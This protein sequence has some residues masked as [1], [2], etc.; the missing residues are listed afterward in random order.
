VRVFYRLRAWYWQHVGS[1]VVW[2]NGVPRDRPYDWHEEDPALRIPA[3]A[4]VRRV[5]PEP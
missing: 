1:S 5:Y 4:H 3:E 2:V